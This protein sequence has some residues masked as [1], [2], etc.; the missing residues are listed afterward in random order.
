[1]P[2]DFDI[3]AD[4]GV[5]FTVASGLVD[6][7]DFE[8]YRDRL[9]AHTFLRSGLYHLA[10]FRTA[11][12]QITGEQSR[13][14]AHWLRRNRK[15]KKMAYVATTAYPFVRMVMGWAEGSKNIEIDVFDDIRS[16][17]QWL[18]LPPEDD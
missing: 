9:R 11:D 2:I 12:I 17:R 13:V 10:D 3:D 7:A 8:R 18:G 15:V 14:I 1:M 16:A 4:A 6:F 5:I